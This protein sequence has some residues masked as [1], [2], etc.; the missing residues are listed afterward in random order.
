MIW[1]HNPH[2]KTNILVTEIARLIRAF[3]VQS[4]EFFR[5]NG[6]IEE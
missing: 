1:L 4:I 3:F 5:G 6:K 2:Y